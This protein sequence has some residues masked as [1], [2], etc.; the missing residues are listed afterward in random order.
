[1][2]VGDGKFTLI[3]KAREFTLVPWR[4][5]LEKQVGKEVAGMMR[6]TGSISWTIGRS[7]GLGID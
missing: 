7:R 5:T 3:Q 2:S 4:P 1:M 6:S